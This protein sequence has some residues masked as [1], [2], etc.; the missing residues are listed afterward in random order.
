MHC[1]M[2][3]RLAA[4]IKPEVER[5][6]SYRTNDS[7]SCISD[8]STVFY[9]QMKVDVQTCQLR[10]KHEWTIA[11]GSK[12]GGGSM[13]TDTIVVRLTDGTITGLGEAAPTKR[14]NQPTDAS[15]AFL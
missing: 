3:E 9:R 12:V 11:S 8:R 6:F 15:L 2:V 5:S 13:T 14:Y 1:G 7:I 10:L 4:A